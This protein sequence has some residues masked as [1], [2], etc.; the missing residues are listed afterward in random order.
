[1]HK[2]DLIIKQAPVVFEHTSPTIHNN[3]EHHEDGVDHVTPGL[4]AGAVV[5]DQARAG[6]LA[7]NGNDGVVGLGG[8]NGV[9]AG[10]GVGVGANGGVGAGVGAGLN[11]GY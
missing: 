8:V 10:V 2:P 1:V 7:A 9:G 5:G 11:V 3:F 6:K 4:R